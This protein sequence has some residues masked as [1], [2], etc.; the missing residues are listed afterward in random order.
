MNNQKEGQ[1][2]NS[3]NNIIHF[4]PKNLNLHR[5]LLYFLIL[6]FVLFISLLAPRIQE[7]SS[8]NNLAENHIL[9]YYKKE[10][11]ITVMKNEF[12]NKENAKLN[13]LLIDY[14]IIKLTLSAPTPTSMLNDEIMN[15]A[16]KDLKESCDDVECLFFDSFGTIQG[17]AKLQGYYQE[18]EADD[19][20][21]KT[22]CDSILV[23]GGSKALITAFHNL[24]DKGNTLNKYNADKQLLVN[25]EPNRVKPEFKNKILSSNINNQIEI[26]VILIPPPGRSVSTCY[27]YVNII[28]VN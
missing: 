6:I 9:N 7:N 20:G 16:Y 28:F 14:D 19:W 17:Y 26:G 24:I 18:Y 8:E 3:D 15:R 1:V 4:K 25:I 11:A 22:K 13:Q 2:N 23:T 27:S 5:F 21:Q 10:L 12:L